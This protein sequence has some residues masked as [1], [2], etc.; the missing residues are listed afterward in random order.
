LTAKD[1]KALNQD[2]LYNPDFNAEEV[3]TDM[4]Q[5]FANSKDS[6]D[7]DI[8]SMHLEGDGQQKL[9]L[10]KRPAEKVLR[11]R[12]SDIRLAGCQHFGFKEYLD[13]GW[14][15]METDSL[16]VIQMD[17]FLFSWLRFG[18]VQEKFLFI[19]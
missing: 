10:F 16:L 5:R 9:E 8:I 3:D 4:L 19:L 12:M 2:V 6:G 13:D 14:I 7:L 17:Q 1:I 18:L 11:D 15:L